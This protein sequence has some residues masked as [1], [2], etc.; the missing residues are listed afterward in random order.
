MA[1]QTM[2][3]ESTKNKLDEFVNNQTYLDAY[4]DAEEAERI[5][6]GEIDFARIDER[7]KRYREIVRNMRKKM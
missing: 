4:D 5:R 7:E 1:A 3:M 6:A 2:V